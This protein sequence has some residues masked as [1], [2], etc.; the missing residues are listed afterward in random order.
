MRGTNSLLDNDSAEDGRE[1]RWKREKRGGGGE[2]RGR[3]LNKISRKGRG[4]G[5]GIEEREEGK[6]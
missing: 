4:V 3:G 5:R 6:G 2:G 1:G